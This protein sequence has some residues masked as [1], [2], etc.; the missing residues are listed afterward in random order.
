MKMRSM[1]TF[2]FLALSCSS[3]DDTKNLPPTTPGGGFYVQTVG[4]DNSNGIG[5]PFAAQF[6]DIKG[7]W[8]HDNASCLGVPVGDASTWTLNSGGGALIQV[9]NGRICAYWNFTWQTPSPWAGCATLP[10]QNGY[11]PIGPPYTTPD[12]IY[13]RTVQHRPHHRGRTRYAIFT[14]PYVHGC[15]MRHHDGTRNGIQQRKW[16]AVISIL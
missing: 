8:D 16:N 7:V 6:I 2:L 11:V 5:T 1:M 12:G 15:Y 4:Q 10:A 14:V 9:T 13:L 3:C